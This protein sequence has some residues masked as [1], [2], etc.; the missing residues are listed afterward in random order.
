MDKFHVCLANSERFVFSRAQLINQ[1]LHFLWNRVQTSDFNLD[2]HIENGNIPE[3]RELVSKDL[4]GSV[5]SPEPSPNNFNERDEY[6]VVLELP[7]NIT[8]II[9]K[10][11][12][13]N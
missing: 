3:V 11:S 7:H 4:V 6:V 12:N 13:G 8:E 2:W 5:S 10:R 9:K 1:T